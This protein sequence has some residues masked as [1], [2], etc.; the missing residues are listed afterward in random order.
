MQQIILVGPQGSGK[1]TQGEKLSAYLKLPLIVT[2]NIFRYHIKNNTTLGTLA[3]Q[4][5]NQGKLV[6]DEVTNQMIAG[7]L[8][9]SDCQ[10]GFVL[11]GY[12][13]NLVQVQA[14]DKITTITHVLHIA[15]SDAEA[16]RRISQRRT[17]VEHGHVYHLIYQAPKQAEQCD[18]DGSKLIQRDDDTAIALQKRLAIYHSETEPIL[19]HY[20]QRQVVNNINGEQ[21]IVSV[22]EQIKALFN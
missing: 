12:P 1:G 3:K 17:C 14:L 7:R 4:Y 20:Q 22:W 5:I 16:I 21:A 18:I 10:A 6:P 15:I 11:D 2:G 19:Q 8:Q 13:R 9:N